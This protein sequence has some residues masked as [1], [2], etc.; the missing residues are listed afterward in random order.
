MAI[1]DKKFIHFKNYDD[2]ISQAGVGSVDNITTPTSGSEDARNAVYGQIKGS[3]IVFIKDTKQIWTHGQLYSGN[4]DISTLEDVVRVDETGVVNKSELT[5][6]NFE[7]KNDREYNYTFNGKYGDGGIDSCWNIV[8]EYNHEG[9]KYKYFDMWGGDSVWVYEFVITETPELDEGGDEHWNPDDYRPEV[10]SIIN[11]Y[12]GL[13]NEDYY[14]GELAGFDPQPLNF[15]ND[16]SEE[17]HWDFEDP[18]Y[19]GTFTRTAPFSLRHTSKALLNGSPVMTA[20]TLASSDIVSELNNKINNP[21]LLKVDEDGAVNQTA[22]SIGGFSVVDKPY[23]YSIRME[24]YINYDDVAVPGFIGDLVG[25]VTIDGTSYYKFNCT[26]ANNAD[27]SLESLDENTWYYCPDCFHQGYVHIPTSIDLY[28]MDS[29]EA[30]SC[31][32]ILIDGETVRLSSECYDIQITRSLPYSL[33]P[34]GTRCYI[35]NERVATVNDIPDGIVTATNNRLNQDSLYI[36][37][38]NDTGYDVTTWWNVSIDESEISMKHQFNSDEA[39]I[40][41]AGGQACISAG[42]PD[43]NYRR[44]DVDTSGI[45][46]YYEGA[47]WDEDGHISISTTRERLVNESM[48]NYTITRTLAEAKEIEEIQYSDLRAKADKG[49]LIP[50]RFYRITDY[51]TMTCKYNTQSAGHH[52]DIIVQA[53]DN[54]TLS[55]DAK[56]AIRQ[57]DSYFKNSKLESWKLQYD[58]VANS[59]KYDWIQSDVL[60][61]PARWYGEIGILEQRNDGENSTNYITKQINGVTKYLYK[62]P[63]KSGFWDEIELFKYVSTDGTGVANLSEVIVAT[64]NNPESTDWRQS[65]LVIVKKST[66]EIIKT[67]YPTHFW[68]EDN[69]GFDHSPCDSE[70][71]DECNYS[72]NMRYTYE[73]TSVNGQTYYLWEPYDSETGWD[74]Y[75]YEFIGS[76]R[77]RQTFDGSYDSLYYVL[78]SP[79][80]VPEYEDDDYVC[81]ITEVYSSDTDTVYTNFYDPFLGEDLYEI[82]SIWYDWYQPFQLN[83]K[84]VIYRMIDEWGNDC[85]YDFKNIKFDK[86][87]LCVTKFIRNSDNKVFKYFGTTLSNLNTDAKRLYCYVEENTMQNI[88]NSTITNVSVEH[89]LFF[90]K[91]LEP[92]EYSDLYTV[93]IDDIQITAEYECSWSVGNGGND[94]TIEDIR[95]YN[96]LI[97]LDERSVISAYTFN[98][99]TSGQVYGSFDYSLHKNDGKC[100]RNIIKCKYDETNDGKMYIPYVVFDNTSYGAC[101]KNEIEAPIISKND[102]ICRIVFGNHNHNNTLG[103]G[104][105][106]IF[107]GD[108][109]FDNRFDTATN[110]IIMLDKCTTNTFGT[111]T[112][113]ITMLDECT[114]NTF[115]AYCDNKAFNTKTVLYKGCDFNKFGSYC[116]GLTLQESCSYNNFAGNNIKIVLN[117]DSDYN[118]FAPYWRNHVVSGSKNHYINNDSNVKEMLYSELVTLRNNSQLR[119]GTWYRITDYRTTSTT[120][121]TSISDRYFDV[122]VL[123]TSVNTLS[124]E[125]RAC[126]SKRSSKF[127]NYDI[128]FDAWK[129]W[130]CLDNDANRFAWAD[131]TNGKGVIYRM[132]DEWNNDCPYDFKNIRLGGDYTFKLK[133]VEWPEY[134]DYPEES[135]D[136]ASI[137][138]NE[139][140]YIHTTSDSVANCTINNTICAN[141]IGKIYH[142]PF[143]HM[144]G[145]CYNNYIGY[146]STHNTIETWFNEYEDGYREYAAGLN[147]KIGDD[148]HENTVWGRD[149]ILEGNCQNNSIFGERNTLKSRCRNNSL[150]ESGQNVLGN[151]CSNIKLSSCYHNTFKSSCKNIELGL[152]CHGNKFEYGCY[153]I[154][155]DSGSLENTF[156]QQCHNIAFYTSSDL[157]ILKSCCCHNVFAPRCRIIGYN[158]YTS[159]QYRCLSNY[160]F[161]VDSTSPIALDTVNSTCELRVEKNSKGEIKIYSLADIIA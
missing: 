150:Y 148:C 86:Y 88:S 50:G 74:E 90:N 104:C 41:L 48:L 95:D 39:A 75:E 134:S 53:I 18:W 152:W 149:N 13:L 71:E 83:N 159:H 121:D 114:G 130:Y 29:I 73:T 2:F 153:N 147:N 127:D 91:P 117:A 108:S 151:S 24:S 30:L 11:V 27:T 155:L 139:A 57:G 115:D 51:E 128:N 112:S 96:E 37:G 84:G 8:A 17:A 129:I 56:A 144:S 101:Y 120:Y 28:Y 67:F 154:Q 49:E 141:I 89:R 19:V 116:Y 94:W 6:G 131:S 122:L 33:R 146:N 142:L 99:R 35:N 21:K 102:E 68:G 14:H 52:F 113:N 137:R 55:H 118:W 59:S 34:T 64:L 63:N 9:P 81:T 43:V 98:L 100:F 92:K 70:Y 54:K 46:E 38:N 45:Y 125:A 60:E 42:Y 145:N 85:P 106:N 12:A 26:I 87:L 140:H 47:E 160:Y 44:L 78:D 16:V 5:I 10:G 4:V 61:Q 93:S 124:E 40:T 82:D 76:D 136:D 80:H 157:S 31:P 161:N 72:F 119:P 20:D 132:I 103:R 123:A 32:P 158:Q 66:G 77:I 107:T 65:N 109:C 79:L 36:S 111:H 62:V 69:V 126:K 58:L 156:M 7:I 143:N 133:I 15:V 135:Y 110:N 25:T 3:S 22:L 105:F 138:Q 97:E 23:N 1:I